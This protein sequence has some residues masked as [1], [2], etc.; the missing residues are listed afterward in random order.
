MHTAEA[1]IRRPLANQQIPQGSASTPNFN[2]LQ[3]LDALLASVERWFDVFYKIPLT[4][5]IGI[6]FDIFTQFL[7]N[8]VVLFKLSI[9]DEVGWDLSDVRQRADIFQIMDLFCDGCEQIVSLTGMVDAEGSRRG[10]FF[11]I[12]H[13]IRGLKSVLLAEMAGKEPIGVLGT[14]DGSTADAEASEPPIPDEIL[15]SLS[16]EPWLSEILPMGVSWELPPP[17]AIYDSFASENYGV[18]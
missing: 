12:A 17:D 2:R 3:D 14:L 9:L 13:L 15:F 16:D 7:H 10:L 6:T 18:N 11:K 4:D 1:T 5:V 8:L